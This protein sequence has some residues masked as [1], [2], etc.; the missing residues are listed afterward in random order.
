MTTSCLH[1]GPR[2]LELLQAQAA[3]TGR[4][5]LMRHTVASSGRSGRG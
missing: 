2:I 1:L 3:E 4:R 5:R